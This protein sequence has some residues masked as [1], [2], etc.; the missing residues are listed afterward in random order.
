MWAPV[1]DQAM[2]PYQFA[3][4]TRAGV[5]ALSARLRATLKN[6]ARASVVSLDGRS[7]YDCISRAAFLRKLCEVAP[8]L[9]LFARVFY[10]QAS[11][12]QLWDDDGV[13][14]GIR[15]AEGCERGDCPAWLREGCERPLWKSG[16]RAS[17]VGT[18]TPFPGWA[19]VA[20]AA[21]WLGQSKLP[22]APHRQARVRLRSTVGGRARACLCVYVRKPL[23]AVARRPLLRRDRLPA[24][25]RLA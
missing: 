2:R 13:R 10:G 17:A 3:L 19:S 9:V 23:L 16:A 11:G 25:A 14:H 7:A 18:A 15:Q 1:F 22:G 21:V 12:H 8:A 20:A 5:D 6:D 4:R 24:G